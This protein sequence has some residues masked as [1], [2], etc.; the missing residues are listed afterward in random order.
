MPMTEEELLAAV[1]LI[2]E[3]L[4]ADLTESIAALDK[5]CDSLS[6]S[7]ATMK[8][9]ADT[10]GHR[11]RD[12]DQMRSDDGDDKR[13]GRFEND[14]T[15]RQVAA[16][17][18]SRS[19]SVDPAAFSALMST[20]AD[21]KKKQT[22]PMNAN[23]LADAQA[24]ADAVM[25]AHNERAEPPMAGE[26]EISYNIRLARPMQRHSAK[27]KGVDLSLIAA[28]RKAFDG[29]IT[30][31]RADAM[32]AGRSPVGMPEFQHRKI[33]K[34]S[35]GGHTI[36]EFIGNGTIFKQMSRPVRHVAYI[37]TRNQQ[38]KEGGW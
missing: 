38:H 12:G 30:E 9:K 19:D 34:Q 6:D 5:K 1:K 29:I 32:Q 11:S 37:G 23:A 14:L 20:V 18:Q 31:I 36:T 21:M 13:E 7:F 24:K 3:S 10:A 33:V 8:K 28:D 2:A 22:R 4:K 26:D 25:R 27:W 35:P 17:R 15:A 16:D